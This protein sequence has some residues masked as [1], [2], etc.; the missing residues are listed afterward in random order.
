MAHDSALCGVWRVIGYDDRPSPE[1][2][3]T[4][5][6]GSDV[7]GLIVY[8]PSG[9]LSI[10]IAGAGRYDSYFG[11]F[12]VVEAT[13]SGDA[14]FGVVNHELI[15]SSIPE[16]L[17]LDQARPF[18]VADDTLVLGDELTWRRVCRRVS[19]HG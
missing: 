6:Y 14:T 7:D 19:R 3:W 5:S 13:K 9:W 8:D 12:A 15:A 4:P 17:T 11:R 16:L 2:P 1:V 18:R 10:S